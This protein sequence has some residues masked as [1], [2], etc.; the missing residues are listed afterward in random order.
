M[1]AFFRGSAV[2]MDARMLANRGLEYR[3]LLR[4]TSVLVPLPCFRWPWA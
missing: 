2:L 4:S 3:E 1:L